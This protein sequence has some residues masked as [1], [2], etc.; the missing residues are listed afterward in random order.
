LL[1]RQLSHLG[2][3]FVGTRASV[4]CLDV[5]VALTDDE[6]ARAP[7][8]AYEFGNHCSHTTLVDFTAVRVTDGRRELPP[9]DPRHELRPLHLDAWSSGDERIA[10]ASSTAGRVC[11]DLRRLDADHPGPPAWT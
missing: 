5:A 10:Y 8:V 1:R 2:G 3:P 9:I 7:I 4:G 11:V 6:L